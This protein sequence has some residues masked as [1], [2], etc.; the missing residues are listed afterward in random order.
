MATEGKHTMQH[1]VAEG[2]AS[3]IIDPL[4]SYTE[5]DT[6]DKQL[7]AVS[8]SDEDIHAMLTRAALDA[9]KYGSV[10]TPALHSPIHPDLTDTVEVYRFFGGTTA[11]IPE[12]K[13]WVVRQ[14]TVQH[15]PLRVFD[16]VAFLGQRPGIVYPQRSILAAVWPKEYAHI[17]DKALHL[18]ASRAR[19]ELG[20]AA[21]VNYH[22]YGYAAAE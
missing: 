7:V 13:E 21:I 12:I 6:P 2:V 14:G 3:G 19:D 10:P 22:G 9:T 8:L 15:L 17:G 18:C 4:D 20:R 11:F 16:L 1:Y 5:P